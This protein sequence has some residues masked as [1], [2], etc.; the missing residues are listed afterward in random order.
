MDV[1]EILIFVHVFHVVPQKI[2]HFFMSEGF[3]TV[4]YH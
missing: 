2:S 1:I 3:M 4:E